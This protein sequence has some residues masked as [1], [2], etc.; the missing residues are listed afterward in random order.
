MIVCI[1]NEYFVVQAPTPRE[2]PT[3]NDVDDDGDRGTMIIRLSLIVV[4]YQLVVALCF[5]FG[6]R[7][8]QRCS[9]LAPV[10][11]REAH[12]HQA[13]TITITF[14]VHPSSTSLLQSAA[15]SEMAT[16]KAPTLLLNRRKLPKQILKCRSDDQKALKLLLEAY[17]HLY[18][19][20]EDVVDEGRVSDGEA[21]TFDELVGILYEDEDDKTQSIEEH[22]NGNNIHEES[23]VIVD[24]KSISSTLEV[25]RNARNV[26]AAV[27]LLKR[28]VDGVLHNRQV[29]KI[30]QQRSN[31]ERID[32]SDNLLDIGKNE[33]RQIYKAIISLLGHTQ[34]NAT[35]ISKKQSTSSQLLLHLLNHHMP[36][37]AKIKPELEIYHA[38]LNSLGRC[39]ECLEVIA[40]LEGM[41]QSYELQN[42]AESLLATRS[43]SSTL[44]APQV[45]RMAYQTAISSLA[46]HGYCQTATDIFYR[47]KSKG[48]LPDMNCYNVLLTGIAKESGKKQTERDTSGGET[49]VYD[50]GWHKLAL[51]ILQEMEIQSQS[52]NEGGDCQYDVTP[53][54]QTY[55]SVISACAKENAWEEASRISQMEMNLA[56]TT[57]MGLN[58][59]DM[60][61]ISQG[62][63]IQQDYLTAYFT[64]LECYEKIGSGNDSWWKIGCYSV[65]SFGTGDNKESP[66]QLRSITVGLQ[67]HRNPVRNGLS[68]VFY[69]GETKLGR[70][71]LKNDKCNTPSALTQHCFSSIVGMEVD[72][73]RRGE[74]LSKLF[75][76]IWLRLCLQTDA[77]PRAALM[78]K[79]LISLVLKHF[80]FVPNE[81]G[82]CVEL[83]RVGNDDIDQEKK[84]RIG[85]S[86]NPEFALYSP[87]KKSL[88]GLFSQRVLRTQNIA[89]MDH[90][91]SLANREKG[92]TIYIKTTFEHPITLAD[93]AV[94]YKAHP[95]MANEEKDAITAMMEEG[96][97]AL[98]R[99]ILEDTI[100][101]VIAGGSN[102]KGELGFF[103]SNEC[104]QRAFLAFV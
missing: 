86:Y 29:H 17:P 24:A 69:D 100:D 102:M 79:P 11:A 42:R 51:R 50:G 75:V 94:T 45:D 101:Y 92:S 2:T 37:V 16:S 23:L 54:E 56:R 21:W 90:P 5:T 4:F 68:L 47:M 41:E 72:I 104:L 99:Q 32:S 71:L 39:G 80:R 67:P 82:V 89:I 1:Q 35:T 13:I 74:G 30:Q 97:S 91:P 77:Y 22:M 6:P 31:G 78:N 95:L 57:E 73:S 103:S 49:S 55:N 62:H 88:S 98:Q 9:S 25:L 84:E 46:K 10:I 18:F 58:V 14:R 40:I 96:Q 59:G 53:T 93:N 60:A 64:D 36:N 44:T 27:H 87:S 19:S 33:L 85:E 7:D 12:Q 83:I 28:S 26:P 52:S 38:V 66:R 43:E 61:D 81:G 3:T 15:P 63:I 76:A 34:N 70:M 65:R 8:S 48:F 20:V